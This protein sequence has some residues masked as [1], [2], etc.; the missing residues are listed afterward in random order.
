MVASVTLSDGRV[1]ELH[2]PTFGQ[3]MAIVAK[4][5]DDLA[6]LMYAKCAVIC[7]SISR[8]EI[9]NLPRVDGRTLV[10]AV[11][12]VWDGP[13]EEEESPLGNGSAIASTD[14]AVQDSTPIP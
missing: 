2:E 9:E 13:P 11:G 14:S 3:E 8:E 4:G 10:M 7:P 6:E 1:I 5:A 12:R